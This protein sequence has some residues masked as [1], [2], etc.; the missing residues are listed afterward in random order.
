MRKNRT[1]QTNILD[2][3]NAGY[4]LGKDGKVK[5]VFKLFLKQI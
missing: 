2:T 4:M 1:G 5:G 3:K